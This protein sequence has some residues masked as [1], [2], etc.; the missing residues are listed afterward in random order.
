M[1][2]LDRKSIG[3]P[4]APDYSRED[5]LNMMKREHLPIQYV[6][7]TPGGW[8]MYMFV[9]PEDRRSITK[10]IFSEL[11]TS[12]AIRFDAD[13]LKDISRVMRTPFSKYW[14]G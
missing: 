12:F 10:K 14:K 1:I 6:T 8:H 9:H 4:N 7:E 11:Q 13:E 2:D 3:H 5:L